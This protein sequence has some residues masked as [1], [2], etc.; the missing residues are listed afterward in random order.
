MLTIVGLCHINKWN[1]YE[2]PQ[3]EIE[4]YRIDKV[5]KWDF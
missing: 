3:V 2:Y 5:M 4:D 1:G